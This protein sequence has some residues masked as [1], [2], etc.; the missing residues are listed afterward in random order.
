[1]SLE[2]A[3]ND[4]TA[5]MKQLIQIFAGAAGAGAPPAG[6]DPA[7]APK[8]EATTTT[9]DK[10]ERKPREKKQTDGEKAAAA[11]VGTKEDPALY[12]YE[13][14]IKP[15]GQAIMAELGRESFMS[16]LA[17]FG[18]TK[19]PELKQSAYPTFLK[20]GQAML[21]KARAA[22]GDEDETD[23]DEDSVV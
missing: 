2:Q 22:G 21:D 4:C 18:V 6:N 20:T 8:A 1:M 23:S 9:T 14:H 11:L 16:L 13:E 19:A 7:P 3:I 5:T 12:N 17:Q 15:L 10:A